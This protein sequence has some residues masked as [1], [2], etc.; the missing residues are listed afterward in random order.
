[1]IQC[2]YFT[3]FPHA[4]PRNTCSDARMINIL[5]GIVFYFYNKTRFKLCFTIML[6]GFF[7][8]FMIIF[9]FYNST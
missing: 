6:F 4:P 2:H 5:L 9:S 3:G 1:M 8:T 7:Y